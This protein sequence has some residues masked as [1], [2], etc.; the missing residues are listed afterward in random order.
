MSLKSV[1]PEM[2]GLSKNIGY[3]KHF[4]VPYQVSM[5]S[6]YHY[7]NGA[8]ISST[9]VLSSA[10]CYKKRVEIRLGEHNIGTNEGREQL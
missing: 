4:S 3:Q 1:A 9:W 6:G 2:Q 5:N 8:L 7:C 10:S